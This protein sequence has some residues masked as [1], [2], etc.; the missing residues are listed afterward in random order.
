M[1]YKGNSGAVTVYQFIAP[2]PPPLLHPLCAHEL[3]HSPL[4]V[5]AVD[6]RK[7]PCAQEQDGEEQNHQ[8]LNQLGA[9]RV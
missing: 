4:A 1:L 9:L 5:A 3:L 8:C 6:A 2:P 7:D